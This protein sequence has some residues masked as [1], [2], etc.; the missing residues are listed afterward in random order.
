MTSIVIVPQVLNENARRRTIVDVTFTGEYQGRK[1]LFLLPTLG[2]KGITSPSHYD[3]P[4]AELIDGFSRR[5]V[6]NT[7]GQCPCGAVR[8]DAAECIHE[9]DCN[10]VTATLLSFAKRWTR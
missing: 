2:V 9:S 7:T 1:A 6:T 5:W 10:A 8:T 4:P 3:F